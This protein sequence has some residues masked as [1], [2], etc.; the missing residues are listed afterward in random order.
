MR[1]QINLLFNE[2]LRIAKVIQRIQVGGSGGSSG[3]S[4]GKWGISGETQNLLSAIDFK[5]VYKNYHTKDPLCAL[6]VPKRIRKIFKIEWMRALSLFP[7]AKSENPIGIDK[8][9]FLY[10]K[11][12]NRWKTKLFGVIEF[13]TSASKLFLKFFWLWQFLTF[14]QL[15]LVDEIF[16]EFDQFCLKPKTFYQT[17]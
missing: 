14:F 10:T 8:V 2:I 17:L 4:G 11:S 7:I 15:S 6:L 13:A 9:T 16:I 3:G 1:F 12:R 5:N